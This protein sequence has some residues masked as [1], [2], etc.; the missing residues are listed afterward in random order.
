MQR[1]ACKGGGAAS[2]VTAITPGEGRCE[3]RLGRLHRCRMTRGRARS[4]SAA[5]SA[6]VL[7]CAPRRS[8]AP[9]Y[10]TARRP[11]R[12]AGFLPIYARARAYDALTL[13]AAPARHPFAR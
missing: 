4:S 7:A 6:R 2:R 10:R 9:T 3:L 13:A 11:E 8:P 1:D 12:A 5:T